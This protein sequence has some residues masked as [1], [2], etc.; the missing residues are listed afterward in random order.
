MQKISK[1][2]AVVG[3]FAKYAGILI[4]LGETFEFLQKKIAER[5]PDDNTQPPAAIS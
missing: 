1:I 5:F 4:V 3:K 2:F